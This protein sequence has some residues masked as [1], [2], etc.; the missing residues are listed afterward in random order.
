MLDKQDV[1]KIL[2]RLL[3]QAEE[4]EAASGATPTA[5]EALAWAIGE[6]EALTD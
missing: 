2:N 6:I 4:V 1:L 3:E 5:Q